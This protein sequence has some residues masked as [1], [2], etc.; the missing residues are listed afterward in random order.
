MKSLVP[1]GYRFATPAHWARCLI[2][3]ADVGSEGIRPSPPLLAQAEPLY[4]DKGAFAPSRAP[5]GELVWRIGS[6]K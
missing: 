4:A 1:G 5:T 2:G 6:G 3:Q